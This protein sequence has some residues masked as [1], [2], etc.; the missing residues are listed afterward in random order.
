MIRRITA[1]A[2]CVGVLGGGAATAEAAFK[3]GTYKGK[4][5]QNAKISLK[6]LSSKKAVV[7]FNWEGAAFG[8]SDG[9]NGQIPGFKTD[10]SVKIKLKKNGRFSFSAGNEA[11]SLEF[12]AAG[13]IKGSRATGAL[14]V[15]LRVNEERELDPNGSITC[16]SEIVEWSAKRKK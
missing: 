6:V 12:A 11:G 1:A 8:C 9:Q 16:D 5:E 15:Q 3:A 2:L 10:R 7:N 13:R 14:Q 4:T